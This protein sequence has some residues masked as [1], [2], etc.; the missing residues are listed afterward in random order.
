MSARR[1][2]APQSSLTHTNAVRSIFI[3][4]SL[5]ARFEAEGFVI[6]PLLTAADIT[7]LTALHDSAP[8]ELTAASPWSFTAMTTDAAYRRAMSDGIRAT[9]QRRLESVLER[10]RAILGTFFHKQP[11][12]EESKIH[13]HQDW[14]W[15][16]E[17]EHHSL[18]VW[19]PFQPVNEANGTLAVVPGSNRLS[20]RPRGFV[21]RFPYPYLEDMLV[22]KYSKHLTLEPGQAVLFHQRLFHWSGPNRTAAR[23][24][25]A[26]CLVAP[27]EASIVFPHTDAERHPNQ[28]ELFEADDR[29]LTS[30]VLGKRPEGARCLGF[31]DA[32]VEPLDESALQQQLTAAAVSR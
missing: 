7:A 1:R 22:A 29:L 19:C 14:S 8:C 32:T 6:V 18:S 4:S 11:A 3:D 16:D 23:R 20:D 5:Q 26:N 12:T 9:L 13:L 17:R 27:A 28:I 25:A 24:L 10:C 30:F 21:T 31:V 15:V 2:I